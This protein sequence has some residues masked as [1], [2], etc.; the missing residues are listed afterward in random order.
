MLGAG[1]Q[2]RTGRGPFGPR[3]DELEHARDLGRL[4]LERDN[5]D[6][7]DEDESGAEFGL[8]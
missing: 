1:G 8:G 3:E 7:A 2:G 6:S 5:P 4:T